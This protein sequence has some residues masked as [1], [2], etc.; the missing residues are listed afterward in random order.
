MNAAFYIILFI[1]LVALWF[2]LSFIFPVIGKFLLRIFKD[3]IDIIRGK[4][5]E[6]EK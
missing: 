5:S 1:V 6:D 2:L 4:E 3:T